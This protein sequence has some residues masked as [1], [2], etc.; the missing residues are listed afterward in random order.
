MTE[1]HPNYS[2]SFTLTI[3][4]KYYGFSDATKRKF[5]L[6]NLKA[7]TDEGKFAETRQ[8]MNDVAEELHHITGFGIDKGVIRHKRQKV[9]E[10]LYPHLTP[11]DEQTRFMY[12]L[13]FSFGRIYHFKW[14]NG[15]RESWHKP[16]DNDNWEFVPRIYGKT[17][18]FQLPINV[19][20]QSED[21]RLTP[22]WRSYTPKHEI[23]EK[24]MTHFLKDG[25]LCFG[26]NHYFGSMRNEI[27]LREGKWPYKK[28]K[29]NVSR[30]TVLA[31]RPQDNTDFV[32][33]IR[34]G[35]TKIYKIGKSNDPKGRLDSLQ[36]A[37]PY[38]LKLVHAFS[39]DNASAAEEDLHAYFHDKRMQGEWFRLTKEEADKL[40][41]VKRFAEKQFIVGKKSM[42]I[43]ELFANE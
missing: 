27:Y 24:F 8:I 11:L 25:N 20:V 18:S 1:Y 6:R 19:S 3:Y 38:K 37:N 23:F 34:M 36:T 42:V 5:T 7:E 40:C 14:F 9:D 43:K 22:F 16:N 10:V 33:L 32:Y 39:A 21:K 41:Q 17:S 29:Q 35:P 15:V 12:A 26:S 2:I 31:N 28:R 13:R 30:R 4:C